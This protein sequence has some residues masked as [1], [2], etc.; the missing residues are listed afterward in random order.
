V[1][2]SNTEFIFI[3]DESMLEEL[4]LFCTSNHLF[5]IENKSDSKKHLI[6]KNKKTAFLHVIQIKNFKKALKDVHLIS[7]SL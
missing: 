3:I 7:T 6:N 4:V 1:N 2:F 5:I